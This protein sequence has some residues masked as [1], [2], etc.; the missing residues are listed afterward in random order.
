MKP[1]ITVVT[2]LVDGVAPGAIPTVPLSLA[3]NDPAQP[4]SFT[5]SEPQ[6]KRQLRQSDLRPPRSIAAGLV[7]HKRSLS[8]WITPSL[9][10]A[11]SGI[12]G[13]M[14]NRRKSFLTALRVFIPAV[15]AMCGF[16]NF[17]HHRDGLLA[18]LGADYDRASVA[19]KLA[20]WDAVD[21]ENAIVERGLVATAYR[22]FA[23]WD[24]LDAAKVLVD[25]PVIHLEKIGEAPPRSIDLALCS[26][27]GMRVLDLT[28]VIAGPVGGRTPAAHGANVLRITGPHLP[29]VP[30]LV[31]DAGRGKRSAQLDLRHEA[32]QATLQNLVRDA[33]VF[34]QGY[35]PGGLAD[36]GFSP[37]A[38]A[39]LRPGIVAASLSAYGHLGPWAARRGFDSLVQ[40]ALGINHAE[41]EAAG[42]DKPKVLPC[43]ALDH[44]SGYFLALGV[45]AAYYDKSRVGAG[46]SV[47]L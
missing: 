45:M 34:I 41:A 7:S 42:S 36:K 44:A 4:S 1:P 17:P 25:Q 46:L 26:L 22:S 12:F 43:Q 14:E 9:N 30:P 28:R 38:L 13:S 6:R 5:R 39:A 47:S 24:S 21:F 35:R 27:S 20:S 8:I 33:D 40:N 32:G 11:A 23:E 29:F 3:G 16:T 19:A 2:E 15:M 18:L 31:I 37:E 10:S